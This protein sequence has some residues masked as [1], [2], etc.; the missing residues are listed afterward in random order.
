M[1]T[2]ITRHKTFAPVHGRQQE[3]QVHVAFLESDRISIDGQLIFGHVND[4][5]SKSLFHNSERLKTGMRIDRTIL[6]LSKASLQ[7]SKRYLG[8]PCDIS[9]SAAG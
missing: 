5:W 7:S 9:I 4:A 6:I 1:T 8:E 3:V 2:M